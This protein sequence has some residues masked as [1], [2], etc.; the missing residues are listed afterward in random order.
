MMELN[1]IADMKKSFRGV[2]LDIIE[3]GIV[4]KKFKMVELARCLGVSS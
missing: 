3:K 4:N 1:D 2:F